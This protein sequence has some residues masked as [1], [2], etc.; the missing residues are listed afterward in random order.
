MD[1][2][3]P[4]EYV[5][6]LFGGTRSLTRLLNEQLPKKDKGLYP[7]TIQRWCEGVNA[8]KIPSKYHD[9]LLAMADE[10]GLT[11]TPE[12]LVR[13]ASEKPLTVVRSKAS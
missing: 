12:I 8:G 3:S 11:L 10:Q 1:K 9:P 5:I 6:T 4:A 7:S 2:V 13:G